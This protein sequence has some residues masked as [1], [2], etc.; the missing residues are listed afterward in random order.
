MVALAPELLQT[1]L[2]IPPARADR[3]PRPRLIQ[4]L[5]ASLERPL[6]LICAPAGFGKTTLI[7]DW[8]EQPDRPDL[9]LAWLSLDADDD[10]PARFLTYLVSA[11]INVVHI[12]GDDLLST[13]QS[14]QPPPPPNPPHTA[15]PAPHQPRLSFNSLPSARSACCPIRQRRGTT[16]TARHTTTARRD[17]GSASRQTLRRFCNL[18]L[19]IV[20]RQLPT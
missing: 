18:R 20:G 1:K 7:T 9:P 17:V 11:L 15:G 6:T 4:R 5:S 12:D 14:P 2:A 10:D 8:H 19:S 16:P 13:L 3:V